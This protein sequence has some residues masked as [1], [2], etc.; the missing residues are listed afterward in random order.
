MENWKTFN[1]DTLFKYSDRVRQLLSR[2][3]RFVDPL[4]SSLVDDELFSFSKAHHNLKQISSVVIDIANSTNCC[5]LINKRYYSCTYIL[6]CSMNQ[7]ENI[8][9]K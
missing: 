2:A 5:Y 4:L 9:S 1:G 3:K 7:C 8:I 6:K